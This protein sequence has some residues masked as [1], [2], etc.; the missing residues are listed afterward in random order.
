M[1]LCLILFLKGLFIFCSHIMFMYLFLGYSIPEV[2]SDV[3]FLFFLWMV[4]SYF[5]IILMGA[6]VLF[7]KFICKACSYFRSSFPLI[8]CY[9]SVFGVFHFRSSFRR[10]FF[11]FYEWFVPILLLFL[12]GFNYF[13]GIF[14]IQEVHM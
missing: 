3:I 7:R 2:R 10:N 11:S 14:S 4:C 12:W 5:V 8:A 13:V 6:F 1:I 9:V